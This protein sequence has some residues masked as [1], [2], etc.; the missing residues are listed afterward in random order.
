M[1]TDT[2]PA[3]ALVV[4]NDTTLRDGDGHACARARVRA[5]KCAGVQGR[6]NLAFMRA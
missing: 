1:A 5:V 6:A 3:V 4:V 2:A